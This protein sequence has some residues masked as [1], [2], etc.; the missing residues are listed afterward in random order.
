MHK[1]IGLVIPCYN[2]ENRINLKSFLK[3]ESLTYVFVNDGS[4]DKTLSL[5]QENIDNQ[6]YVLN[7]DKNCGKAE[8]VRQGVLFL[9]NLPVFDGL[10]WI[11]YWDADMATP[12]EEV[13]NI[14]K[15][16]QF[17][18]H[19]DAVYGSRLYRL[20]SVIERSYLRHT[21]GRLFASVVS[22]LFKL[23]SYD[24]QCGAKMFRKEVLDLAFNE[25]FIS[26]WIF[27]IEILL[28]LNEHNV[29][30]YPLKKWRDVSGSTLNILPTA[31]KVVFDLIKIRKMY[32]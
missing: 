14:L 28:R 21:L 27:D 25:P 3:L 13:D 1:K 26:R 4:T 8:A 7:L 6:N 17:Y 12:I 11:G 5:L 30:E 23:K 18:E 32:M 20:G 2:E 16:V 15:F 9:K 24:S 31:K 22:V 29:I 10:E 19:V